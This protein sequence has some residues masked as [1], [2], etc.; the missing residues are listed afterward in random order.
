MNDLKIKSVKEA[1]ELAIKFKNNW[2]RGQPLTYGSL[3]PKI[4]RNEYFNDFHQAFDPSKEF[5]IIEKFKRFS[6]TLKSGLPDKE[7]R[8]DW[9]ILMQHYGAP[10][11]LLD[12]TESI[13]VGLFFAVSKEL[14]KDGEIWSMFPQELN[15]KAGLGEIFP[16]ESSRI[17]KFLAGE[18]SHTNP[19]ELADELKLKKMPDSPVAFYPTLG[20]PRMTSQ[21][22][23]FT[24]H[25]KIKEGKSINEL[26]LEQNKLARY[27]IPSKFKKPIMDQLNI[28]GISN[29]TLFQDL[30]SLSKDI[31]LEFSNP[32]RKLWGQPEIK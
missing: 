25:P 27:I 4:Y 24:I 14:K 21:L 20:F 8:L 3:I 5:E 1:V 6:P 16:L 15:L 11:R 29:R 13:L 2:W 22:S 26:I 19:T 28:L 9:L 23:T 18:P 17:L 30:E 7:N 10:T 12:W 32:L 31:Q